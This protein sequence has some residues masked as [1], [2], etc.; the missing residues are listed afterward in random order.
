MA[1]ALG[2][3]AGLQLAGPE[4]VIIAEGG[5]CGVGDVFAQQSWGGSEK[6]VSHLEVGVE[7]GERPG[8]VEGLE[9][10]CDLGD[11]D[12]EVVDVHAVDAALDHVGRRGAK[13]LRA[14]FAVAH[15]YG[16]ER[17]GDPAGGGYDEM[18]AADCRI[19]HRDGQQRGFPDRGPGGRLG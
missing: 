5:E 1:L 8:A 18:A 14:W 16:S 7:E 3:V 10:Q 9:P 19:D 15:A 12:S 6:G 2:F 11:L 17:S 4:L 13:G